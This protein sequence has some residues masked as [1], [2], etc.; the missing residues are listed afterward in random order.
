[1]IVIY[2]GAAF[3]LAGAVALSLTRFRA[4]DKIIENFLRDLRTL[5]LNGSTALDHVCKG[6]NPYSDPE[7]ITLT[8][9]DL[10]TIFWNSRLHVKVGNRARLCEPGDSE[11]IALFHALQADHKKLRW[12]L[13]LC[14]IESIVGRLGLGH[15]TM[16]ARVLL[17]TYG[18]ELELLN[19]ISEKC[20]PTEGAAIRAIL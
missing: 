13:L 2:S 10:L 17:W 9:A 19:H 5:T 12:L 3:L 11:L 15:I 7:P 8:K 4:S 6:A 1:M 18:G 16:Y 20:G 14:A